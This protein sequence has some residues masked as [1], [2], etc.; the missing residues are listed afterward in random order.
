MIVVTVGF[1]VHFFAYNKRSDFTEVT[2]LNHDLYHE[3]S[4]KFHFTVY[5]S[6]LI[7]DQIEPVSLLRA[8]EQRNEAEDRK[9]WDLCVDGK[10]SVGFSE[11]FLYNQI[12]TDNQRCKIVKVSDDSYAMEVQFQNKRVS[13]EYAEKLEDAYFRFAIQ[14][15]ANVVFHFV[16]YKIS[17][18]WEY[19][20]DEIPISYSEIA[21]AV[22]PQE[23]KSNQD[24]T[25]AF[26]GPHETV[27]FL[28]L[29]PTKYTSEVD[30]IMYSGYRLNL[31]NV[32]IGDTANK[33]TI[34]LK[35]RANGEPNAGM[36]LELRTSLS[37]K[38][39]TVRVVRK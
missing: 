21:G 26:K 27:M 5:Y 20:N 19:F 8:Q 22:V 23:S 38:I 37:D 13:A 18:I 12:E 6:L 25:T 15:N 16:T 9:K 2:N 14:S 29:T 7:E 35:F 11:Y 30:D 31:K 34:P 39:Y 36:A 33:R 3:A 10:F 4:F 24:L 17:S 32:D 28:E 1:L